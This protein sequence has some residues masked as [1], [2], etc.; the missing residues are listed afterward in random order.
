[1]ETIFNELINPTRKGFRVPTY[2]DIQ[3]TALYN[4]LHTGVYP[5]AATAYMSLVRDVTFPLWA[6]ANAA[7]ASQGN[8]AQFQ[9]AEW[10]CSQQSSELFVGDTLTLDNSVMTLRTAA[11]GDATRSGSLVG[12]TAAQMFNGYPVMAVMPEVDSRPWFW[13]PAGWTF[14]VAV[15]LETTEA[16][17]GSATLIPTVVLEVRAGPQLILP[18]LAC[19]LTPLSGTTMSGALA[20]AP[21]G[22]WPALGGVWVRPLSLSLKPSDNIVMSGPQL[23]VN[24]HTSSSSAISYSYSGMLMPTATFSGTYAS[25]FQPLVNMAMNRSVATNSANLIST[26]CKVVGLS[27]RI[28]NAT[29]VMNIEG[30]TQC[31]RYYENAVTGLAAPP[32]NNAAFIPEDRDFYRMAVG[33]YTAV[34]PSAEFESFAD[35]RIELTSGTWIC[36]LRLY[37]NMHVHYIKFDDPDT[38]TPSL[39]AYELRQNLE[40]ITNDVLLRPDFSPYSVAQLHDAIR[41]FAKAPVWRPG[42]AVQHY[43]LVDRQQAA[44]KAPASGG[45]GAKGK[46]KG[47]AQPAAK[48]KPKAAKPQAQKPQVK[49]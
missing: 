3:R 10:Y 30:T 5:A 1:M 38:A 26:C 15:S 46:K 28:S 44:V 24:I 20:F 42:N 33:V 6:R 22:G 9:Q 47:P 4:Q 11:T 12:A 45:K 13:I 39:M 25:G 8:S 35:T 23:R 41:K 34:R 32:A 40:F 17:L 37:S 43:N 18:N 29:K 31:L 48:P 36:G 7:G 21:Q 2:P 27:L 14:G 19:L 16:T 49:K